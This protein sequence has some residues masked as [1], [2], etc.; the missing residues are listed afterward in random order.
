[1]ETQT[2]G[3][4]LLRAFDGTP[5]DGGWRDHTETATL[6]FSPDGSILASSGHDGTVVLRDVASGDRIGPPL[7]TSPQQESATVTFDAEGHLIV[8]SETAAS[9]GGTSAFV[10]CSTQPVP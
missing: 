4:Q 3:I 2:T 7:A 9:G 5:V 10:T 6:A 1:M 8:A